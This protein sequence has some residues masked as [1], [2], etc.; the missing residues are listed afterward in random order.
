MHRL[1][2][3]GLSLHCTILT[4]TYFFLRCLSHVRTSKD[5]KNEVTEKNVDLYRPKEKRKQKYFIAAI[6]KLASDIYTFLC[7]M[8][9]CHSV[10]TGCKTRRDSET[11]RD[12]TSRGK[13]A[14]TSRTVSGG[15]RSHVWWI[16]QRKW[17]QLGGSHENVCLL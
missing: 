3:L 6:L 12:S 11:W 13:E 7:F 4:P 9:L 16:P 2:S 15:R 14:R 17:L 1:V 8:F 10:F 5:E